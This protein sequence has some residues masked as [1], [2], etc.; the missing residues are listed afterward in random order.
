[1]PGT[2]RGYAS[3]IPVR[4]RNTMAKYLAT[5]TWK[6]NDAPFTDGRYSR[7]HRW[8]FDGGADIPGSSS[9]HVVALPMS[10]A[11][12]VDP[13]EAFVAALSSCHM[14]TF[15]YLAAKRGFVV[16]DY[17]DEAIG[18]MKKDPDGKVAMTTVTLRPIVT[19]SGRQ[20]SH[21]EFEA[22]HHQAHED[23]FIANSVKTEVRCQPSMR[24]ASARTSS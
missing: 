18:E 21:D 13:E 8:Q 3:I 20:P 15:L 11:S 23:C 22:M 7:A 2:M 19:V 16:D 6:R 17:R 9:P 1:M 12:A 24:N 10:D 14:L 4:G 5:I